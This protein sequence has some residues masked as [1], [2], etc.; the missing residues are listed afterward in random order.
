MTQDL[1]HYSADYYQRDQIIETWFWRVGLLRPDQLAALCYI[2]GKPFWGRDRL[3]ERKPGLVLSVG[4]GRG[5]LEAALE[6][7]GVQVLGY[8]PSAGAHDMYEGTRLTA[9]LDDET[10]R[11]AHTVVFCESLEH[12]PADEI[13]RIRKAL[14]SG[15]RL[16]VTNWPDYHPIE[17]SRDGWDHITRVDDDL[18][19]RL[20]EGASVLVRR[21]SHLVLEVD[22]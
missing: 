1:T 15:T 2:L 22:Q 8:D 7:L 11:V 13:W 9:E 4:C 20:A 14:T 10:I 16:V 12:V 19:D 17:V 5:E 3:P 18:F 6:R 21:E